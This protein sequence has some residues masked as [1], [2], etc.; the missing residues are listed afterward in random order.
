MVNLAII[1]FCEENFPIGFIFTRA[2]KMEYHNC[3]LT[4]ARVAKARVDYWAKFGRKYSEFVGYF[5][6]ISEEMVLDTV[7]TLKDYP[8]DRVLVGLDI[9]RFGEEIAFARRMPKSYY[10][11]VRDIESIT[12]KEFRDKVEI[13]DSALTLCSMSNYS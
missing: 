11:L 12:E 1:K 2:G 3:V 5:R 4:I 8:T 6:V 13:Y 9:N 10:K 7:L